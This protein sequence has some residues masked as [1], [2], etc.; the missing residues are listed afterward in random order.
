MSSP[1][2]PTD[3]ERL[4]RSLIDHDPEQAVGNLAV[5]SPSA[6]ATPLPRLA[7]QPYGAAINALRAEV[8]IN[9]SR[10]LPAL[11][12]GGTT[13]IPV[14]LTRWMR[15]N[16]HEQAELIQ[17]WQS[18]LGDTVEVPFVTY[19]KRFSMH[20]RSWGFGHSELTFVGILETDFDASHKPV[21]QDQSRKTSPCCRIYLSS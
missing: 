11:E 20:L 16:H 10:L 21:Y 12:A 9:Y 14:P 7:T 18:L 4:G 13:V 17:M 3:K 19:G 6:R 2:H 15:K 8:F 5:V 1:L